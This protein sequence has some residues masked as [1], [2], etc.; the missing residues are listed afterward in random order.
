MNIKKFK[1]AIL[2]MTLGVI[3]TATVGCGDDVHPGKF[4]ALT[5]VG[6]N[7]IY[8]EDGINWSEP[9]ELKVESISSNWDS[10]CYGNGTFVATGKDGSNNSYSAHSTNGSK[11]DPTP[12][13]LSNNNWYICYGNGKFVAA[14][15]QEVAYSPDGKNWT[16]LLPGSSKLTNSY[17]MVASICYGNG[18]FVAVTYNATAIH[19]I[20]YS[21]DGIT[22]TQGTLAA[23]SKLESV[24]YGKGR[25]VAVGESP[26]KAVYSTD[27]NTWTVPSPMT[28]TINPV[29]VCYGNGKFIAIA[30][31]GDT[32]YSADGIHWTTGEHLYGNLTSVQWQSICYGDGKFVA[33]GYSTGPTNPTNASI[34]VYS[35]DGDKWIDVPTSSLPDYLNSVTYGLDSD[36]FGFL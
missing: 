28:L 26:T 1:T 6:N 31:L 30:R 15:S 21:K 19:Q 8:S 24:C 12:S 2:T 7:V 17:A 3:L 11:W 9:T 27:G 33:V 34:I 5:N 18:K 16:Q 32:E 10:V 22:W 29:S 36:I 13:G 20:I 25:F 4:V 14:G 35:T 23:N